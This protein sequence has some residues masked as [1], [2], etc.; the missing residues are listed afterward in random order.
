MK[1]TLMMLNSMSGANE[2]V[3]SARG[4]K[5]NPPKMSVGSDKW[6]AGGKLS[7]LESLNHPLNYKSTDHSSF[8]DIFKKKK[9]K[10]LKEKHGVK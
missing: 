5:Q 3:L 1:S 9:K 8:S 2:K 7:Y 4:W 6:Q 10:A